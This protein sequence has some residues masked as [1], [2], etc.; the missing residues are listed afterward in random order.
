MLGTHEKGQIYCSSITFKK[1][2]SA[3]WERVDA[4]EGLFG[5]PVVPCRCR[6]PSPG[7][8]AAKGSSSSRDHSRRFPGIAEGN[9]RLR[10]AGTSER[11][12]PA[13]RPGWSSQRLFSFCPLADGKYSSVEPQRLS[14]E[15]IT[16]PLSVSGGQVNRLCW[17]HRARTAAAPGPGEG[18]QAQHRAFP[19]QLLAMG[20]HLE[21]HT[22]PGLGGGAG[23][24][25][26]A[27]TALQPVPRYFS[28]VVC[29][30]WGG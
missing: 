20:L 13:E 22:L 18:L 21:I 30:W 17:W 15:T 28:T 29:V 7:T 11:S 5:S 2:K 1:K 24:R 8:R 14:D 16:F 27:G 4:R 25:C 3:V 9:V 10:K 26:F 12:P 19:H 23:R 6:P